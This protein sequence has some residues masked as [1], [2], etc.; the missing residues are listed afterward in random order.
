MYDRFLEPTGLTFKEMVR[1]VRWEGDRGLRPA[2]RVERKYEQ[3]GFATPSGKVELVPTLLKELECEILPH[4][5]EYI[6]TADENYPLTL[7]TGGR[8]RAFFHS[9]LRQLPGLRRRHPDPLVQI[10]PDTAIK[11]QITDGEWVG[12]ETPL[13]RIKHKAEVTDRIHPKVVHIEHGWWF[14]EEQAEAPHLFGVWESNAEVILSNEPEVCD[15]Q[16]GPPMRALACR[17][18]KL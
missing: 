8:V 12:I 3:T 14:P 6:T 7:I 17:L 5:R 2:V 15:Y 4:Y 11:Y 9:T 1:K 18:I 10:H 13:G 16:G